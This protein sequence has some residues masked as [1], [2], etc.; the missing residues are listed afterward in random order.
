M[1]PNPIT[2]KWKVEHT[3][4]PLKLKH[5]IYW[6]EQHVKVI[7]IDSTGFFLVIITAIRIFFLLISVILLGRKNHVK[8]FEL[9]HV[10]SECCN[11]LIK[12]VY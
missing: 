9:S 4:K 2:G 6:N 1:N 11:L 3:V 10:L 8:N 5:M 12:F 7:K